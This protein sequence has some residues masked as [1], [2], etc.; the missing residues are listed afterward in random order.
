MT[1]LDQNPYLDTRIAS[2]RLCSNGG[3]LLSDYK[4]DFDLIMRWLSPP[5]PPSLSGWNAKFIWCNNRIVFCFKGSDIEQ[6]ALSL[7]NQ[8]RRIHDAPPMKLNAEM[9]QL[10]A[11]YAEKLAQISKLQHSSGEER[12]G[13]GENLAKG[14]A[15][16][17]PQTVKGAIT[18]W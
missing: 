7:H 12:N 13:D 2:Y 4:H 9:S 16:K 1:C 5:L 8:F 11:S 17:H 15:P 6:E 14:C 10:A 18:E 3:F